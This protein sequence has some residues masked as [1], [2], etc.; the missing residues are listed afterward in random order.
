ML[1]PLC[2]E[3]PPIVRGKV[4]ISVLPRIDVVDVDSSMV[5]TMKNMMVHV[6]MEFDYRQLRIDTKRCHTTEIQLVHAIG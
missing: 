6:K 5:N 3:V 1:D 4:F 2:I